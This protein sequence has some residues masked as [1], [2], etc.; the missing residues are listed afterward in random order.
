MLK[1]WEGAH[2]N[3][4]EGYAVFASAVL[5][6]TH[7][8]VDKPKIN[9]L[10]ALYSLARLG[11]AAAYIFIEDDLWAHLRSTCWWFSNCC[12]ISLFVLAGKRI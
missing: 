4:V 8:G 3:S 1:R 7:A 10:M 2:A 12:C 11:Y 5:L 6:A 9:G